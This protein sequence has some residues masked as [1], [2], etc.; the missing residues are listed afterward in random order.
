MI[1]RLPEETGKPT[2]RRS[3]MKLKIALAS[4]ALV[5]GLSAPA[6][7]HGGHGPH[8]G[9]GYHGGYGYHGGHGGGGWDFLGSRV[10]SH[11]GERDRVRADGH[12]RYSQVKL[13]ASNR[14]VRVHDVDVVFGNGGR[15]DLYVRDILRPGQCTRPIDLSG[16]TRDIRFVNL[17][18]QTAGRNWGPRAEVVVFAR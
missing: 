18:Y 17:A 15:Q 13:C 10:V 6:L 12:R 4:L 16:R 11:F 3:P 7:A 5:A 2:G 9:H 8:G 14:A 1:N